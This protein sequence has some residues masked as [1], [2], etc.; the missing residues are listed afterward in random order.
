MPL[1]LVIPRLS[2]KDKNTKDLILEILCKEWPLTAKS[3][4]GR[5]KKCG[6]DVTY[7]A[8][9]KTI[10]NLAEHEVIT[11]TSKGYQ[12]NEEWIKNMHDFSEKLKKSYR[13]HEVTEYSKFPQTVTFETQID[14]GKFLLDLLE[15]NILGD[16]KDIC[17]NWSFVWSHYPFLKK[18]TPNLNQYL[19]RKRR[20]L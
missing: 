1:E 20:T 12:L 7:Q 9:H 8:V 6:V 3:I 5:V 14:M 10:R 13:E 16:F 2:E 17:C 18:N 4:Y 15:K 19:A 11:K